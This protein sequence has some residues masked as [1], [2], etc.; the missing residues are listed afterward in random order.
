MRKW[1]TILVGIMLTA[2]LAAC[3]NDNSNKGAEAASNSAAAGEK[4]NANTASNKEGVPEAKEL[5]QNVADAGGLMSFTM[6]S[7]IEQKVKITADGQEQTQ[8]ISTKLKQDMVKEPIALYQE[9]VSTSEESSGATIKQY[10]TEE[11][12]YSQQDGGE[13]QKLPDESTAPII[14]QLEN[15]GSPEQ[16]FKQFESIADQLTVTEEGGSYLLKANLSGDGVKELAKSYLTA[17]AGNAEVAALMDQMNIQSMDLSYKVNK[18]T[19]YPE[20]M[21]AVTVMSMDFEGRT[22]SMTMDMKIK[23]SNFNKF[24]TIEIP[25]DV[26][27]SASEA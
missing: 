4:A 20:D 26:K 15:T 11:G 6:D 23:L 1:A 13:W 9:I 24:E 3:G 19:Y 2:S 14:E 10:I 22:L 16:Q 17:Q 25:D 5:I 12:I 21:N 27:D 7:T 8:N 18:E